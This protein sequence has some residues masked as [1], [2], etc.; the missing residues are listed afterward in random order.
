MEYCEVAAQLRT[1]ARKWIADFD[2]DLLLGLADDFL[3][4]APGRVE[5]MRLAVGANDHRALTHEAHT[6]KSSCTH[7]G[8]TEL[9]AM[10]KALEVAGR[11]GEAASLSDQVAQLEQHFI[12]VRQAVER[13]VDNLDEFLVEN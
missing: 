1:K 13:M 5:R 8:A 2:V 7:V 4:D 10:S 11:A 12:L 3:S 9:E 6:L